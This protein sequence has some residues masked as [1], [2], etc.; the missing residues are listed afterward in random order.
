M[1][2]VYFADDHAWGQVRVKLLHAHL[3]DDETMVARFCQR[4]SRRGGRQAPCAIK[5]VGSRAAP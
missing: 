5:I 1:G 2:V 4:S 3:N